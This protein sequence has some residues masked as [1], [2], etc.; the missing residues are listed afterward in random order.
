MAEIEIEMAED[1]L[2]LDICLENGNYPPSRQNRSTKKT[3]T[4]DAVKAVEVTIISSFFTI[5]KWIS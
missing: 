2:G 1:N 4:V 5:L 3:S